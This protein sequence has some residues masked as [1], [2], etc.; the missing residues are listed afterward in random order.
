M[1][2]LKFRNIA[3]IIF[4]VIMVM[5]LFTG[6]GNKQSDEVSGDVN[7]NEAGSEKSGSN[8]MNGKDEMNNSSVSSKDQE[9]V[10]IS[11]PTMQCGTCKKNIETAVKKL[12]GIVSINVDKTEKIAHINYDKTKLDLPEIE[13]SITAAGYNA[14]DKKADPEAYNNLDD[15]CKL[16]EDQKMKE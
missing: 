11:L 8:G 5:A 14:N 2:H 10:M 15:C 12:D 13:G 6:C 16:P 7:K 9:H 4:S 3:M 1:K